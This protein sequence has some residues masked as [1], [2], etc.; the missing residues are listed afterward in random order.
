MVN[1]A[2][3]CKTETFNY[4]HVLKLDRTYV[5]SELLEMLVK[6]RKNVYLE[7]SNGVRLVTSFEMNAFGRT[8]YYNEGD[9]TL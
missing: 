4:K 7:T 5:L 9:V 3:G 6:N 2:K 1:N 8:V